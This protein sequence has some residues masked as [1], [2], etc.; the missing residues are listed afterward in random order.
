MA[1]R[2]FTTELGCIACEDLADFGAGKEGWLVDNPNLL[3]ALD[4]HSLALANR[5]IILVLGWSGSDGYRLKIRPSDL[6]PI[7]AEYI[8]A[9]EWLVLD[10]IKVILVGTSC[11]YFLIYSLSGDLILKQMIHPGRILKI[12]VHGSK[13]DLSH[14]SSLEEVSVAM[15]GVIARIEGSD[16]QN[17][18]Q[19]WFQESNARF[20][21]PK[22]QQQDMN[23]SENSV[24]KLAYQV[25]NVSKY[26][27]CADAAITGVM[28][29]PLM[30]LQSSERYFCAVTVGEDA[31]ISAFRL[32][33]D[34]SRSLVGAILSKVVPAT[35]STIAS[36]SKMIWRSEPKTSK[37]PDAKGQAF[38]RASPL[39]CLKDHP[40]KGEKLTL[41]PSGTL[42]AITD[43]LGRILLLDTQALVVVRLWKGYR[44]A[45]CLFMEMLVN[46][47]T[48]SSS[49][50]SMD[51]EP[52][53]N[54][55]CL[56]LAIHAPR[57]GIVEI[58][59]M[60]TGRRLRTIRCSKGSKLLQPSS[61]FGSSMVSPYVPLEVF[62]LNGDSG[63]ISVLNR[64]L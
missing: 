41:S 42:A 50:N 12:R 52:A 26:G 59:Q 17:T 64:T 14:G 58:W 46:R 3:C 35:F 37:K 40:R 55:Y 7:E 29:P 61:R 13:R 44:D 8:S 43:S 45:N 20:W 11:G 48:A 4:S 38:A 53:K 63:Q 21:D 25:W 32:S 33:E 51:Y 30:E 18:L 16:I 27:A 34:K 24:E 54:D 23:D 49:S 6:S 56:C 60:R 15:P 1:R 62:L 57:K 22:S 5:S 19:K 39:T 31:V 10:E 28:P 9:L 2:T 47:D 36:F